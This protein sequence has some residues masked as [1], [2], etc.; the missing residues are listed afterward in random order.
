MAALTEAVGL[1][2]ISSSLALLEASDASDATFMAALDESVSC[3]VREA[4]REAE[5]RKDAAKDAEVAALSPASLAKRLMQSGMKNYDEISTYIETATGTHD[6]EEK[7][8]C[9]HCGRTFVARSLE[10]HA[11][12]V[13]AP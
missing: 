10:R 11:S 5:A 1:D 8:P 3:L 9:P 13:R 6:G 7:V 4:V 12:I 2:T